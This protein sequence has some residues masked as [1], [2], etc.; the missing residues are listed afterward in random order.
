MFAKN[1]QSNITICVFASVSI[2]EITS[3]GSFSQSAHEGGL[4]YWLFGRVFTCGEASRSMDHIRTPVI[5]E[6]VADRGKRD[7]CT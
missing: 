4:A 5:L 7:M 6:I 2:H 1:F 3:S